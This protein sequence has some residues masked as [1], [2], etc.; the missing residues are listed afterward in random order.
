M[1]PYLYEEKDSPIHRLDPRTKILLLAAWF[2][3]TL[4]PATLSHALVVLGLVAAY[5]T[6]ARSWSAVARI[7]AFLAIITVFTVLVWGIIPRGGEAV[8]LFISRESLVFGL[9]TAITID[10]IVSLRPSPEAVSTDG[11][12]VAVGITGILTQNGPVGNNR[13]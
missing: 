4:A 6:I 8:V 11:S 12:A 10:S 13:R 3:V 2:A 7:R 1:N 5:V 9:L